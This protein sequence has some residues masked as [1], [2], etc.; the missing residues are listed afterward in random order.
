VVARSARQFFQHARFDA[1]LPA[2]GET[3]YRSLIRQVI[4][5]DPAREV[6]PAERIVIPG[7]ASLRAFSEA[8]PAL[9]QSE[10]GG[11]WQ[12]YF[13]RGHWRMVF[14]FSRAHQERTADGLLAA[15]RQNRPPVVHVVRFPQLA[16]NHAVLV[17]DAAEAPTNIVFSVYDPNRPEQ[18][19]P[20]VFDRAGRTFDF[21]RNNYFAGG[22]VDIYEIYRNWRY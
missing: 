14:P 19:V 7:Y 3:T 18:P 2:V 11:A 8:Q 17:F 22:R 21:P 16:I 4:A 10:C 12:S 13:Q 5:R 1:S 20:L 6:P 15:L 9:L